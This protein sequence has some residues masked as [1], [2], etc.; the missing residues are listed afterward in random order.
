MF[1]LP[2]PHTSDHQN[3]ASIV[4]KHNDCCIAKL[5]F[6]TNFGAARCLNLVNESMTS[7][8]N[9]TRKAA[10]LSY[11]IY[12]PDDVFCLGW[13]AQLPIYMSVAPD[14]DILSIHW[15]PNF[16]LL[17]FKLHSPWKYTVSPITHRRFNIF[18]AYLINWSFFISQLLPFTIN[19]I[20]LQAHLVLLALA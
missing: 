3:I 10:Q 7:Y 16:Q 5:L 2:L 8:S 20:H 17:L 13:D 15:C 6:V 18:T 11:R 1:A 19:H 14:R 4:N 12:L 9:P